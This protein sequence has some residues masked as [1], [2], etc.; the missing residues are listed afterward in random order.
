MSTTSSN[1]KSLFEIKRF[2]GSGFDLWKEKMLGILFLKDW[3]C[4]LLKVKP[5]DMTNVA[6][7]KLKKKA[8]TYIKTVVSNEILVD[9]KGYK[10][11]WGMRE[12]ESYLWNYHTFKSSASHA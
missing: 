2:E 5:K 3:E 12:V 10:C 8:I 9:L 6:W 11:F 1:L 7:M 4:A